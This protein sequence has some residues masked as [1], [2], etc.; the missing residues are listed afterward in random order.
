MLTLDFLKRFKADTESVW[1][2]RKLNPG[3]YGFQIQ[4]ETKWLPGLTSSEI[5]EYEAVLGFSFPD[6]VK[7]FLG[8]MNGLDTPEINIYGNDGTPH[9][10]AY[11]FYSYPRDLES[12]KQMVSYIEED[13]EEILDALSEEME[14]TTTYKF[15]P[16]YSHRYVVCSDD[17][18]QST[19]VSIYGTDAIV[20]GQNL[21]EYLLN[22]F[23]NQE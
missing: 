22:E 8:F 10:N 6:D 20:Y 5:L 3:I 2:A 4:K 18:R 9:A 13:Y 16:I 1:N 14:I 17:P 21:Q 7:L 19:V 15:L 11:T 12:V 23:L